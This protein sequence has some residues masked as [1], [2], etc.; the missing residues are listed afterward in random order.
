MTASPRAGT[1]PSMSAAEAALHESS[2][3]SALVSIF[4]GKFC[5]ALLPGRGAL[6]FAAD[7]ILYD[8]GD[9]N[10][11]VFFV[12]KGFVKIGT[13]TPEGREVIYDIRKD[14]D[15]VGE[16][17][18][19]HTPR[20]DR[21]VAL[22]PAEA[23][24]VPYSEIVDALR[25]NPDLLVKLLEIFCNC[26]ADAYDQITTLASQDLPGRLV[27]VLLGLASKIG[28]PAGEAV[29]IPAYLTQEEISQ[30]V[31]ARRERVSTALNSL[32]RRGLLEY[33][34]RGHLLL[35]VAALR[36]FAP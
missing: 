26:L 11:V 3:S 5:D 27:Q 32:R 20:R 7:E 28:R 24:R 33:S 21:A 4:R 36:D 19:C 1:N 10:R 8:V 31:G 35:H 22:E 2:V 25:G 18:A 16:I 12:R 9:R 14:G 34:S 6:H 17:C 29:Q 15:V 13:L 23:I 30:M